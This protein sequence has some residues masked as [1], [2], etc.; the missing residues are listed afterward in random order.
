M[1]KVNGDTMSFSQGAKTSSP[2]PPKEKTKT[3]NSFIMLK[4][5]LEHLNGNEDPSLAEMWSK[6]GGN[7]QVCAWAQLRQELVIS[8]QK[9]LPQAS[10]RRP[11]SEIDLRYIFQNKLN[12]GIRRR[13]SSG[14][15][16]ANEQE[17]NTTMDGEC[18]EGDGRDGHNGRN[19]VQQDTVQLADFVPFYI[20]WKG[21]LS[22]IY[23]LQGLW[24][25]QNPVRIEGFQSR[26][27][28]EL[29]LTASDIGTFIIRFSES[30]PSYLAIAWVNHSDG[31]NGKRIGHCLVE[32]RQSGFVVA[33][34]TGAVMYLKLAELLHNLKK[35]V[36]LYPRL[37][38]DE[39]FNV[40][41]NEDQIQ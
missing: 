38:K 13:D 18:E 26:R 30:K 34:P 31:E 41:R 25:D 35:L 17:N 16:K 39:A 11:L 40:N 8:Y 32:C 7:D 27:E 10:H 19:T 23:D 20:W 22:I 33:F 9:A 28:T 15:S 12:G 3:K 14:A 4:K 36:H 24:C 37:H 5:S 29:K 21:V 6:A 1:Q 2:L